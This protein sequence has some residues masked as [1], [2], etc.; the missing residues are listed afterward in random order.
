MHNVP[1]AGPG[2]YLV[3]NQ[4]IPRFIIFNRV[5]RLSSEHNDVTRQMTRSNDSVRCLPI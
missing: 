4:A 1:M 3:N 2:E 5:K